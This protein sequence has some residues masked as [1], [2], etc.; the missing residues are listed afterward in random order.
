MKRPQVFR[1]ILFL[2]FVIF[3]IFVYIGIISLGNRNK[4]L[5]LFRNNI[6]KLISKEQGKVAVLVKDLS[7]SWR[8]VRFSEEEYFPAASL[9]KLPLLAVAFQAMEEDIISWEDFIIINKKDFAGGSG[10]IKAMKMPLKLTFGK[11]CET[12]IIHSDN[13]ATN[14]IIDILCFDYINEN[15]KKIGLADTT[16]KR[17]MMD[18]AERSK[19]IENYTSTS[20]IAFLLEKI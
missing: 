8:N 14:K 5:S 10:I 12:S 20:D 7:S 18:F 16:L 4:N 17:K 15:F 9:I 1:R 11:L 6:E 3:S 19:G 13:T 2:S